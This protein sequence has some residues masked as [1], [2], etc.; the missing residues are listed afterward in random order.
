MSDTP[1][2]L[3]VDCA[4]GEET[5]VPLTPEEIAANEQMAAEWEAQQLA[6]QMEAEALAEAKASA[7]AKLTALGLTEA[8]ALALVGA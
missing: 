6:L 5:V 1:T 4:T 2:K 8:E 3:V 7:I